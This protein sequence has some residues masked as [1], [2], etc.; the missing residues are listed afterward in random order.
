[1]AEA[2]KIHLGTCAWAYEDWRDVFYPAHLPSGE[3]LAYYARIFR[4][5]EIDSTFY[6]APSLHV[7]EHW[8]E[9]T[10]EEFVF[11]AKIP[12]EITHDRKLRDCG[13]LLRGF[14]DR[15]EPLRPKMGALLI[16]LPPYFTL[17]HDEQAFREFVR[18][19]PRDWRFAI[20]FR[21]SDWHLPRTA[22]LLEEHGVAW[23]WIDS[24]GPEQGS[25]GA[26]EF[27]P[28]T[29]KFAYVRLMGDLD[30]KYDA[31]GG[32]IHRYTKLEWQRDLALDT[33]AERIRQTA[34]QDDDVFVYASNHFEGFG[35]ETCHRMADRIDPAILRPALR[36]RDK[37]TAEQLPL[38]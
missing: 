2:T 26:L 37:E 36:E 23:A 35:P 30:A 17:E 21:A 5:V 20:E 10:P 9:C 8:L 29:A 16:Q 13:E 34:A 15:M 33:W 14:L 27:R 38:F 25:E 7:A 32:R 11:S 1:M 6:S 4:S 24:T 12:R 31:G 18:I 22:H 28:R 3:R 19:L